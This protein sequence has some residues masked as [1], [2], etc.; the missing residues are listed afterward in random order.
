MGWR[1]GRKL[2]VDCDGK[3]DGKVLMENSKQL[4]SNYPSSTGGIR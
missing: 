1:R 3:Y 4:Y 2:E